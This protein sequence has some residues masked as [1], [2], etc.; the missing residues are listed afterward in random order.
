[1]TETSVRAPKT[2][3]Q[4]LEDVIAAL[5][6]AVEATEDWERLGRVAKAIVDAAPE[7]PGN[8]TGGLEL[9]IDLQRAGTLRFEVGDN[10]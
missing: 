10:A 1:M 7:T 5:R 3:Y 8:N 9:I 6:L 2:G 4:E